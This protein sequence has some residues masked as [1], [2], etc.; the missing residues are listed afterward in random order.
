ML[1]GHVHVLA[2]T[3]IG[4][5]TGKQRNCPDLGAFAGFGLA[6]ELE[7]TGVQDIPGK[8]AGWHIPFRVNR[9]NPPPQRVAVHDIIMDESEGVGDFERQC[10]RHNVWRTAMLNGVCREHDHSGTEPFPT[11]TEQ[12]GGCLV[13]F[14]GGM[15]EVLLDHAIDLLCNRFQVR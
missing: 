12:V 15:G 1:K 5:G 10:R 6:D 8:Y 14:P 11:R 4:A 3:D 13:E 9:R 7:C 2:L